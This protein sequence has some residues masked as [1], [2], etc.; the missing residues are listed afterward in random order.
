MLHAIVAA[1]SGSETGSAGSITA[2]WGNVSFNVPPGDFRITSSTVVFTGGGT[3]E[4]LFT[5]DATIGTL[6]MKVDSGPYTVISS[7]HTVD[8]T[9][10]QN[11][12]FKYS[13]Y[14][15]GETV[16][17]VVTDNTLAAT[18]DTVTITCTDVS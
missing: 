13:C 6:E 8:V 5:H 7:G 1:L 14:A 16:T 4:L 11:V 12:S 10:G 17:L 3:R 18:V 9:T 15:V 2:N